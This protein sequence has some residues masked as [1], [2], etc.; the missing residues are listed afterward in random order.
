MAWN[1]EHIAVIGASGLG[2]ALV[3][4]G[5]YAFWLSRRRRL[6]ER[7]RL[8]CGFASSVCLAFAGGTVSAAFLIESM[9][10]HRLAAW[11]MGVLLGISVDLTVQSG[12]LRLMSLLMRV[13][14]R[15]LDSARISIDTSETD[16]TPNGKPSD[17]DSDLLR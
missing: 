12:P 10:G 8:L 6:P 9:D 3:S 14:S 2:A 11:A 16:T 13:S 1:H 7:G 4:S 5:R 15:M 17:S